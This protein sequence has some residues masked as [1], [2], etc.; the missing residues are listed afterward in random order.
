MTRK[1]CREATDETGMLH[2]TFT[3]TDAVFNIYGRTK[4]T[5]TIEAP[6]LHDV[7]HRELLPIADCELFPSDDRLEGKWHSLFMMHD[8]Y[9]NYRAV[10]RHNG[11]DT[12]VI[13]TASSCYIPAPHTQGQ[14]FMVS[15]F[16]TPQ[17]RALRRLSGLIPD[18][19]NQAMTGALH[20]LSGE[21]I[22]A[23]KRAH[24]S[25]SKEGKRLL[26]AFYG[27]PPSGDDRAD[28]FKYLGDLLGRYLD[29]LF[30]DWLQ[31][32][33]P[34]KP[35]ASIPGKVIQ[36]YPVYYSPSPDPCASAPEAFALIM[37]S[38]QQH[39]CH[40]VGKEDA[41]KL[42]SRINRYLVDVCD[43][44]MPIYLASLD[45][46]SRKHARA[47]ISLCNITGAVA[48]HKRHN[49]ALLT[50][51][52]PMLNHGDPEARLLSNTH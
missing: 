45:P 1:V 32:A 39:A 19:I 31:D 16:Y 34:G 2:Y 21:H 49:S 51:E 37:D 12:P 23:L 28:G 6:H 22:E 33:E 29:T 13:I 7:N 24:F 41:P 43:K 3:A 11:R 30:A 25:L 27:T 47:Q 10:I 18:T 36:D 15:N 46:D 14:N 9:M 48:R 26:L 20:K 4:K 35:C 50:C 40:F 5:V 44:V 42:I 8:D 52:P 38:L 17:L